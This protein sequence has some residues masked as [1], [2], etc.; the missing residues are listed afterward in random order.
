M[1]YFDWDQLLSAEEL[2]FYTIDNQLIVS[3]SIFEQRLNVFIELIFQPD[4]FH[5]QIQLY[6]IGESCRI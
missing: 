1:T 5:Y 3:G 2:R 6:S 4:S